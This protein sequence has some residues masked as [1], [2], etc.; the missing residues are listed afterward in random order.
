M[1]RFGRL[2]AIVPTR[3]LR[4]LVQAMVFALWVA[5]IVATSHPVDSW[6][7]RHVPVSLFLR[8]DPLV[9]T[10][11]CG[12]M[13]VAV[14]ITLL[15]FVT[16]AITVVLGRVFCGWL[17][18]L[19]TI[20][21]AWGWV[22]QRLRVRIEGPSPGWFRLKYYLLACILVFAIF[23]AVSPLMGLDP[24][25]LLTR[26]AAAIAYPLARR[27]PELVWKAGQAP[28]AYSRLVDL[29]TLVLFLGI[30]AATTR[31]SRVWCRTSCPLG[32]YL[33]VAS[34]QAVLRRETDGCVHCNICAHHCPTGAIDF[35]DET[36]YNESECIKCYTCSQVCPV[37]ANY[38]T[39]APPFAAESPSRAP[40]S[41]ERRTLLATV[42]ATLASFPVLRLDAGEPKKSKILV[43]P[44]M[45]RE[46]ADFLTSCIRCDECVK[47]CPTGILKPAGLEHG[48][49]ALW[50]PVMVAT[51]GPCLKECNA[52]SQ[53]CPTDAILKYPLEKKYAYKAG[54]AV[55][56]SSRC[57][58]YSE[59]KFCSECVRACPT[60]AIAV[61]PGWEPEG[62]RGA[63]AAAP[64]GQVPKR[65]T[66]VAF[67]LCIGCGACEYECNQVVYGESAMV[68][69]SF[70]RAVPTG[71]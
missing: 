34:R 38:F 64:E 59:N 9:T 67:D 49:R 31:L 20:F 43:R 46:E 62:G 58:S 57:I 28:G 16:L 35:A 36:R 71:F 70:G 53:V 47:A 22:L 39:V 54:T 7:A 27:A 52:C 8:A 18:P 41:L 68:T 32:A 5:L 12:G 24:I 10:V 15:G 4:I 6:L 42:G 33:A 69:T 30:L 56:E 48:L 37:D 25:V 3:R 44:P 61:S 40:V 26:S 14:T 65:P 66:R 51:E 11:V 17:C 1:S 60:N 19:G 23:G 50:T 55:L 13:R 45:A 2:P 21:D 63:D 29:G